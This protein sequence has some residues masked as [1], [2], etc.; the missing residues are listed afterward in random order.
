[1][2]AVEMTLLLDYYGELLT[3]RQRQCFDLRYNQDLS[4]GE[5]AEVLGVSRQGVFDNLSRAEQYGR[6]NGLCPPG[7]EGPP[8]AGR[9]SG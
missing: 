4:M 7:A 1:M 3:E 9:D 8:G 2:D 6:K 5:I